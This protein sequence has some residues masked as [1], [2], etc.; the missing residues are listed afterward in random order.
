[1]SQ[2]NNGYWKRHFGRLLNSA[3]CRPGLAD[4]NVMNPTM[5]DIAGVAD[6]VTKLIIR[7]GLIE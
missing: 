4:Q 6:G 3:T 5:I 2:L 1:M 7:S